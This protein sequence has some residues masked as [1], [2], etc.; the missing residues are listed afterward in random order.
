MREVGVVTGPWRIQVTC[1]ACGGD[2]ALV[3]SGRVLA[4]TET[5]AIVACTRCH[6]EFGI[7]VFLRP[8]LTDQSMEG[9]PCGTEAGYRRHHRRGEICDLC[10]EAHN[11][12]ARRRVSAR[13]IRQLE[14]A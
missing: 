8:V 6:R 10:R 12:N 5:Q 14:D 1:L 7:H 13:K 4:G 9:T 3:A 11:D 2:L